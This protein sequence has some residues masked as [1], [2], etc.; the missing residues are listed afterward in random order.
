MWIH[1]RS[2]N[3][4]IIDFKLVHK[5]IFEFIQEFGI[6]KFIYELI[7]KST[8]EFIYEFVFIRTF[9]ST[10][11]H[12]FFKISKWILNI[13]VNSYLTSYMNEILGVSWYLRIH[14]FSLNHVRNDGIWP[15]L[16]KE[17]I[18]DIISQ[19]YQWFLGNLNWIHLSRAVLW[20]MV[21]IAW[22]LRVAA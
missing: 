10:Q 18:F 14:G 17:I 4:W 19:Q 8:Y 13:F 7:F 2:H 22:L 5:F 9:L 21:W 3:I 6:C 16:I 11:V 1:I 15:F 12:S 20:A